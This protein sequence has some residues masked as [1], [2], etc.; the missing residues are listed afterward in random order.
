MKILKRRND[1]VFGSP[2]QW[3]NGLLVTLLD[4]WLSLPLA[5]ADFGLLTPTAWSDS[6]PIQ[7]TVHTAT[8]MEEIQK[9]LG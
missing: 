9:M 2:T 5:W 8:K 1:Q 4:V 7:G 6:S 3:S